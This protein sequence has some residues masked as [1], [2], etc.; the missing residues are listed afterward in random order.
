MKLPKCMVGGAPKNSM[1]AFLAGVEFAQFLM[2]VDRLEMAASEALHQ[3]QRC[4]GEK[5]VDAAASILEGA[6]LMLGGVAPAGA[7]NL[8][9]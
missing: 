5:D 8:T 4:K 9:R 3:L 7:T 1:Q 2:N 6:L